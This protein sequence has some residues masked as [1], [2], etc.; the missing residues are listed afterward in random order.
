MKL[1]VN[2]VSAAFLFFSHTTAHAQ[3]IYTD[4]I[5]LGGNAWVN[6][7]AL[8]TDSGLK[9]WSDAS[10][11]TSIYF[12]AGVAQT[13]NLFLRLKVDEGKSEINISAGNNK[14]IKQISNT[15]FETVEIGKL[16]I[17]KPGYIK[18]DLKGISKKGNVFADVSDL[19]IQHEKPDSNLVY[20][21]KGSSFHFGRRG[22]S[23]HLNFL[24]PD[25]LKNNVHWFYNEI[26][27]PKGMDKLG[28]YFE[29]DGFDEGY[30]GMQ[31]NSDTERRI[32]F[33]V[34]SPFATDN[35]KNIPDS[36]KI[37]LVKKGMSV[38]S[39]DFGNEGSGGQSYMRFMWKAGNTYGFLLHAEPDSIH[40][41]TT[42]TAYFKDVSADK[43]YLIASFK[44][45]QTVTYLTH[46]Y[47]FLE[48]FIPETGDETRKGF[49]KNQWVADDKN[50]WHELTNA[51]FTVD[52]T[53]KGG[54]R[55]DYAGGVE[56]EKF[57]LKND[58]FFN[59]FVKPNQI[60]KRESLGKKP[61]ID[62]THFYEL[63]Q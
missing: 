12:R 21:K 1:F 47:S 25:D 20:V 27:I 3:K 22:P 14:F 43:W 54:Y 61:A 36:L 57:F 44:R 29:A 51:K 35:P 17:D 49:Y 9:N 4:T 18:I 62:F 56:G 40:H 46:L 13:F 39:N 23:V 41:A 16:R 55:K 10:S 63:L 59:E 33:S 5:P 11:V 50:N 19:I 52:A 58:G 15:N 34:W 2:I 53:A 7:P 45:P 28:S 38:Q 6:E 60:F 8:I 37:V 26:T 42:Y 32:L 48:N 30:F 31:V 24:V